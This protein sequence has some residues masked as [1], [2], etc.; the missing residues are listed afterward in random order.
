MKLIG[1]LD[2][3]YVR[4]VAIS[5]HEWGMAF[6]HD[7]LSV[8]RHYDD[9]KRV[10]PIVKAPTLVLDDGQWL[11][12]STLIIAYL[13][14]L[15]AARGLRSLM[16]RGPA[17][18]IQALRVIGLSLAASEKTMQIVY[19]RHLRPEEKQHAPWVARVTEQLQAAY[20]TLETAV[21]AQ[22]LDSGDTLTQDGITA[23][24]VFRF[25]QHMLGDT[26]PGFRLEDY[27]TLGAYS[28]I[29]EQRASFVQT[30]LD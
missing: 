11:I 17:A 1:M 21:S 10:N 23:A 29:V 24:V 18:R 9:F 16:P 27:P 26:V 7:A 19:E 8:F 2:S 13:E 6:E 30:P 20:R 25:T 15:A 12:D 5:L 22:A 4:R 28:R 14:D 3:P